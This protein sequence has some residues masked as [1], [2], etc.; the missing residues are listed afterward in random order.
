MIPGTFCPQVKCLSIPAW[1]YSTGP[2]IYPRRA[3]FDETVLEFR[4]G[5]F[6]NQQVPA[7]RRTRDGRS[8]RRK[9]MRT[10][11]VV[12]SIVFAA[13]GAAY[14]GCSSSTSPGGGGGGEDDT[15]PVV[16]LTSPSN[17]GIFTATVDIAGTATDDGEVDTV[18]FQVT[19]L[20]D[21]PI[22]TWI[23]IESPYGVSWDASGAVEGSY[24]VRMSAV[25]AAGNRSDWVY[26]TGTRGTFPGTIDGF[27]P[28]AAYIGRE[29]TARGSG[30]GTTTGEVNIFGQSASV[31]TWTDTAVTFIIPSGIP[32]DA[33]ISMEMVIDCRWRVT[34][35]IEITQPGVIR[36]TDH[37][38]MDMYPCWGPGDDWIYFASARS[39]NWDIW[40]IRLDGTGLVQVTADEGFD[41]MPSVRSSSGEILWM[42]DRDHLGSNPDGDYDILSG[43]TCGGGICTIVARTFDNDTNNHPCWSPQVY[44]GYSFLYTQYYDPEDDGYTIPIIFMYSTAGTDSI[45]EGMDG[46]FSPNGDWVVYQDNEY[47]IRKKQVGTSTP[48]VLTR[49]FSDSEPHWGAV[50]DRIVFTRSDNGYPGIFVMDSDGTN[51]ETIISTHGSSETDPSWSWDCSMIVFTAFRSSNYDIYVYEVP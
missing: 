22:E 30:F 20:C 34:G 48:V 41:S 35:Q 8:N 42:S 17:G 25:D 47:Q 3:A 31:Q 43:F 18:F 38:S 4:A 7:D 39:G 5:C 12:V 44:M 10:L 46:C 28:L 11:W 27:F 21:T 19:D 45:G 49:G 2:G 37:H 29:I 16:N 40:K 36:I 14:M 24:R 32:Q 13:A 23:D 51:V 50:N 1:L 15:P 33:I 26:V 6:Y 9:L